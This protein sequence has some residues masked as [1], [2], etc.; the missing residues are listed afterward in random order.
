MASRIFYGK[1]GNHDDVV[2]ALVAVGASVHESAGV[3]GGFPDLVVGYDGA[4]YLIEIKD[5]RL[6]PSRR[7]LRPDQKQFHERWTG[8]VATVLNPLEALAAIGA[9]PDAP[10]IPRGERTEPIVGT[11][12][13]EGL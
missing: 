2:K 3:G 13:Q 6:A 1:D 5:G 9:L 12:L 4:T 11:R 10:P 7:T 8:H